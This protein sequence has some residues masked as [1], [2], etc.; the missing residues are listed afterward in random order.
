MSKSTNEKMS[1]DCPELSMSIPSPEALNQMIA[2]AAYFMAESR[3]F[4]GGDPQEDWMKAE[5][6][7]RGGCPPGN[8]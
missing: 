4:C 6:M 8:N 3:G 5:A 7:M 1:Q 2:E